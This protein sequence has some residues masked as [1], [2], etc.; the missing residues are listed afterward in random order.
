M[1]RQ[2]SV[3]TYRTIEREGL[4]SK[5]RFRVYA[6]LYEHGP[7]TAAEL[8]SKFP[9][10]VGGRGEAGNV[11][12]RLGELVSLKCAMELPDVRECRVTGRLVTVYDVTDLLPGKFP[13][14]ESK[15]SKS[16]LATLR[17][18]YRRH[19]EHR[20]AIETVIGLVGQLKEQRR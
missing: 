18:L 14:R 13:K 12:A 6:M 1:Q 20:K 3:D 8:A 7:A 11:H 17:K 15:F 19:P 2:T 5:M 9:P 16:S 10:S 4:L